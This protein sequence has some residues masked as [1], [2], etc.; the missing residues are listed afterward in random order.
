MDDRPWK[1]TCPMTGHS[2]HT[3]SE[4]PVPRNLPAVHRI[5]G[6]QPVGDAAWELRSV[7]D[8]I[9]QITAVSILRDVEETGGPIYDGPFT[10]AYD[11]RA[12]GWV[13]TCR[14]P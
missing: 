6:F 14:T 13:V 9:D 4:C 5:S 2:A 7:I 3:P 1:G 8:G 11:S 12:C 10:V